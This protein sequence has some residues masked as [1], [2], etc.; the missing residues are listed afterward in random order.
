MVLQRARL[1]ALMDA[2]LPG[3]VWLHGPTGAGKTLLLR[4]YLQRDAHGVVWLSVDERHGDP[5]A[6][7]AALTAAV[8]HCAGRLPAFSPEHRDQPVA[9]ALGYFARLDDA[10]PPDF[11]L[12][13]DDVHHLVGTT[14]PLLACAVDAFAGRR[15]LCFPSQLMPDASFAPQLAGSRLWIV[16][17]RQLAFD[18]AEAR[19]LAT[20]LGTGSGS[21]DA[22]VA[23][24]DGWA[25][26]LMLAMQFGASGGSGNGSGDPLECIRTPLALL[27][28]GQVLGG[29]AKEDLARLRLM[30]ELPQIPM[31]LVDVAPGWTS[32]CARL[33]ALSER[34]LFVE[35]LAGERKPS[36][37]GT[38]SNVTRMPKGFW[39]L[40]D[41]FRNALREPGTIGEPDAALGSEL[42]RHLLAAGRLE[43][44]WQ[45]AARLGPVPLGELVRSHGSAAL[46]D[47]HRLTLLSTAQPHAD[48]GNPGIALWHA[49]GLIGNDNAAAL[50]ACNEAHVGYGVEQDVGGGA[51]ATALALFVVFATIENVGEI[52][53]W[54]ERYEQGVAE[55]GD[56]RT[57][58]EQAISVAGHVVHGLLI[59]RR[60]RT[61]MTASA[62]QDRLMSYVTDEVLSS[63]ETV[64]AGSLLVAAMRRASRVNEA[65]L[66]IVRVEG[67]AS[68]G[69]S[70]PHIRANW[71]I[72]NGY[73]FTLFGD[74]ER[75]RKCF[76]DAMSVAE[77]NA[78]L[79]PRIGAL[80]G[81]VRLELG[82]GE[83]R[84]AR[85]QLAM[86]ETIGPE[87]LGRQRGWVL[88]LRSRIE[89]ITGHP[90]TAL[91]LI[92]RARQLIAEAGFPSSSNVLL[93]QDRIQMLYA[94]GEVDAARALA[95]EVIERSSE[96]ERQR[97]RITRGLLESHASWNDDRERALALLE[98]HL[99]L[100]QSL[101]LSTFVSMLPGVASQLA[102]RALEHGFATDLVERAIRV[103]RLPAPTDAPGNWPWP[104]RIE[105]LRP[106]RLLRAGTPVAFV[107]KSQQKPLELLKYLACSR[108]LMTDATGVA[109]A[110]WPD[111]E[112]G[113]ARKSLEVTVSRLRKLVD[114][115]S[116]LVVKEGKIS[117]DPRRVS[118]DAIEF[119]NV[120]FLAEEVRHAHDH[121][122]TVVETGAR[123]L[124]LFSE[125]P[126]ENEEASSWR[127]GVRERYR[128]TFVRAVRA[129]IAYW[130][131]TDEPAQAIRL[132]EAAIEREPLAEE[133]YRTLIQ[134]HVTAGNHTEALRLYRQ[135]RQ[136]LSVLIGAQPSIETE[137]LRSRIKL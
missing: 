108:G 34:G 45:L 14:A 55:D 1:H 70:A 78:L 98:E 54:V 43:L 113:A 88:H 48:R 104:L 2:R 66:A 67:L 82:C 95:A 126:L 61:S 107:G 35:R 30:A 49:R 89:V 10:L 114:D 92:A 51:L 58:D 60:S 79:Q 134:I 56:S 84:R 4:S 16:G 17:H 8:E 21:L 93:D 83:T 133:L 119:L 72:E 136:M 100:A 115:E 42:I 18:H 81:L 28:A 27:I 94:N 125:L 37:D 86:L 15:R 118:S 121:R 97:I 103:R 106:F 62:L 40:H 124:R 63:N 105:V 132:I 12:V 3:A 65:G 73:H 7:F 128:I 74:P 38:S 25:A 137:R 131:R 36:A 130:D 120:A 53:A 112:D 6:L 76:D 99:G 46:R 109:A 26:G 23:A 135:C 102:G 47:V 75:A 29:V 91:D 127:E 41:L 116:L 123:L 101:N 57:P 64:L 39:R 33:Q 117:L 96:A 5:A 80:I 129:L 50:R 44:A 68:Y 90:V 59:G 87:Q 31:E 9:F 13:V 111:A 22:L 110:L 77:E 122:G 71:H 20:R 85:E 24:T 69:R 11:A 19:E 32:A 52:S